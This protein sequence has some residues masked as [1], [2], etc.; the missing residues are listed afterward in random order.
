MKPHPVNKLKHVVRGFFLLLI[1]SCLPLD[2]PVYAQPNNLL[3]FFDNINNPVP[4]GFP[5]GQ[6]LDITPPAPQLNSFDQ[7]V[8]RTCGPFGSRVTPKQFQQLMSAYPNVFQRLQQVSGGE[9]IPGRRTTAQFLEDLTNI[10]FKRR[11]FT[12]IFCGEIYNARDI[13]GLHFYGRYLEL[14]TAGIGGRLPNNSSREQVIP[15]VIYTLGVQIKQ[16]NRTIVD[17]I[18]GYDYLSSAEEILLSATAAFKA[19]GNTEGACVYN[20]RDR[21][22]GTSVPTIFVRQNNAIVT[23]YP[24]ATPRGRRCK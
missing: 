6:Q 18:K 20:L 12:H 1:V 5:R 3:P 21:E 11:A 10:W 7:A 9:L 8:L 13:G 22:T 2:N 15:G 16:G 19:Q 14:Q 23:F 24:D 4:V 17:N